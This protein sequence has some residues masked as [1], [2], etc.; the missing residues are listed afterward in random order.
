[1]KGLVHFLF[2]YFLFLVINVSFYCYYLIFQPVSKKDLPA[3][4][5]AVTCDT[6]YRFKLKYSQLQRVY[7]SVSF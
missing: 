1:M 3:T 7:H 5:T 6:Y 4:V 2:E